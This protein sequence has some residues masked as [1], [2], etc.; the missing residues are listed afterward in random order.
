[1]INSSKWIRRLH[2][3][4]SA[5]SRLVCLPHAGGA[6]SYFYPVLQ[7]LGPD[8]DVLAIQY[9]GRQDRHAETPVDDIRKLADIIAAELAPWRDLPLGLFG[10]SMGAT[11]AFEVAGRLSRN[12]T[13]PVTLFASGCRAP[14]MYRD[15][16]VHL[17]DDATLVAN[18]KR[19]SGTNARV[20]EDSEVVEMILPALRS[21]YRAVETYRYRGDVRLSCP[22]TVFTG[23]VD[24]QVTMAEALAWRAHTEGAFRIEVFSGGHFFLNDHADEVRAFIREQ[25][26]G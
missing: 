15:Q 20:L 23:D 8:V 6:A 7:R 19:L 22:I 13:P 18:L 14:T 25:L 16:Q 4:A 26:T 2:P 12:G 9:P 1:M 24:P 21:D 3:T 17:A 5:G 11:I 10:H